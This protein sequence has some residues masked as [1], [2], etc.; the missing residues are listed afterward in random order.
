MCLDPSEIL[1][2]DLRS[3]RYHAAVRDSE[4]KIVTVFD[5]H[6]QHGQDQRVIGIDQD[7]VGLKAVELEDEM[8]HLEVGAAVWAMAEPK[9]SVGGFRREKVVQ[10]QGHEAPA[11]QLCRLPDEKAR[12]VLHHLAKG[13]GIRRTGRLVGVHCVTD[14]HAHALTTTSWFL[15]ARTREV[16]LNAFC[17]FA[18]K[19]QKNLNPCRARM[20]Q[21]VTKFCHT[22]VAAPVVE[23]DMLHRDTA[24]HQGEQ[25]CDRPEPQ[26]AK[27]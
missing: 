12:A 14:D 22:P 3:E 8:D 20:A 17:P 21:F 9:T 13:D 23:E 27:S 10:A 6:G 11:V 5:H 15:P 16:Q 2:P 7:V 24:A 1:L 4:E 18:S 26:R 19:R 25:F